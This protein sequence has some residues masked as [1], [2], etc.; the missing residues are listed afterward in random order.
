M[1]GASLIKSSM[2]ITKNKTKQPMDTVLKTEANSSNLDRAN[3]F[4][5]KPAKAKIINQ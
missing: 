3:Q 4:W 2:K 5:Y 1:M